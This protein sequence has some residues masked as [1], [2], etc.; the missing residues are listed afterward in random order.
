MRVGSTLYAHNGVDRIDRGGVEYHLHPCSFRQQSDRCH[1]TR[2]H[3]PGLC[4]I[5]FVMHFD[6]KLLEFVVAGDAENLMHRDI[7]MQN[8]FVAKAHD[9]DRAE[10]AVGDFGAAQRGDQAVGSMALVSEDSL[11]RRTTISLRL[12]FIS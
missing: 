12:Q 2:L 7:K 9:L 1:I 3:R 4:S 6:S 11:D 10:L 8:M 5:S